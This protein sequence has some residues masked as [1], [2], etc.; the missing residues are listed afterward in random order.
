[1]GIKGPSCRAATVVD[2]GNLIGIGIIFQAGLDAPG[3][4][5]LAGGVKRSRLA[6]AITYRRVINQTVLAQMRGPTSF[7]RTVQA[8]E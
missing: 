3:D 7:F 1:M 8:E 6:I 4:L 2:H 5:A